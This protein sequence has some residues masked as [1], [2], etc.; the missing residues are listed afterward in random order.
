M[1][2]PARCAAVL[3]VAALA[4]LP[5]AS[6]A[7]S[8]GAKKT[9]QVGDDYYG[10]TKLTVKKNTTIEWSWLEANIN[11]HDVKLSSGPKGVKKFHSASAA[12]DYTFSEK[13][14]AAGTYKIIC[15]LHQD[16]KMTIVVKK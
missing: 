7:G 2:S 15:T 9:V 16:M 12:S 11:S 3:A 5:A 13:L 10:P 14:K 6:A 1:L 4:A 8:A